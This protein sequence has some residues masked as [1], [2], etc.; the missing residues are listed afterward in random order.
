MKLILTSNS[1]APALK[2]MSG[3]IDILQTF[4][5]I[6][7]M[8]SYANEVYLENRRVDESVRG[9]NLEDL[10]EPISQ[11]HVPSNHV[12]MGLVYRTRFRLESTN[13]PH[14]HLN[15]STHL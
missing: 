4:A 9:S 8:S 2:V 13:V 12:S 11:C 5:T 1:Q 10:K 7:E 15:G 6:W 3:D 14:H